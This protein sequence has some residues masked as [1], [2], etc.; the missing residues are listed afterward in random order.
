ML[1]GENGFTPLICPP[2][3]IKWR[4]LSP[5][6]NNDSPCL[7]F[8]R[9]LRVLSRTPRWWQYLDFRCWNNLIQFQI[10]VEIRIP[11]SCFNL[12]DNGCAGWRRQEGRLRERD[13]KDHRSAQ[14]QKEFLKN[15]CLQR[16]NCSQAGRGEGHATP[17][18]RTGHPLC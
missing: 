5:A 11:A 14:Q 12:D 9:W 16:H 18:L 8:C 4:L 6:A 15:K 3:P 2:L 17:V 1:R 7:S 13:H 10:S